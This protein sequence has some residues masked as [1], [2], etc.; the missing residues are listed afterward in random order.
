MVCQ[1]GM[2]RDRRSSWEKGVGL[3]VDDYGNKT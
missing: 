3:E 1:M 2:K